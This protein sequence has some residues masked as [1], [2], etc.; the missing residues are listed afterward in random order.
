M[1][2]IKVLLLLLGVLMFLI[3]ISKLYLHVISF[4]CRKGSKN[5]NIYENQHNAEFVKHLKLNL[6]QK[7]RRN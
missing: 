3:P 2:F 4:A 5:R 6:L 7:V 1:Y